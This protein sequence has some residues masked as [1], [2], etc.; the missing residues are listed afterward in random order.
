MKTFVLKKGNNSLFAGC[1]GFNLYGLC[2]M[3]DNSSNKNE[4]TAIIPSILHANVI[5]RL[6]NLL[7][8]RVPGEITPETRRL[9]LI[10]YL[11]LFT[12][13]HCHDNYISISTK[14]KRVCMLCLIANVN[15]PYPT[16]YPS[17][18]SRSWI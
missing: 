7:T 13:T 15:S 12:P 2:S 5:I 4:I 6:S 10:R 11:R 8:K 16:K 9:Y 14:N 18:F 3:K 1:L 17:Y